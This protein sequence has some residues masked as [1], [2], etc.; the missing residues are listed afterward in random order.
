MNKLLI[1]FLS[2]CFISP[3]YAGDVVS[4][5][6]VPE[7][8]VAEV[9]EELTVTEEQSL[10]TNKMNSEEFFKQAEQ[11]NVLN[12]E[13]KPEVEIIHKIE[14]KHFS[15]PACDD[16][17]LYEETKKFIDSYFTNLASK[18]TLFRRRHYFVIKS[19]ESFSMEDVAAYKTT[20]K[21]TVANAI[22]NIEVNL[23]LNDDNLRLCKSTSQNKYTK[24]IYLL[25]YPKDDGY[26]VQVLNL[27]DRHQE[28]YNDISFFYKN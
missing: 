13:K 24:N 4:K 16:K 17:K 21:P 23:G 11:E 2:L 7:A 3:T 18:G 19:L 20:A 26:V 22:A 12:A 9:Q 6:N 8:T 25:I 1:L 5:E 27:L 14:A 10:A 15:L 28:D